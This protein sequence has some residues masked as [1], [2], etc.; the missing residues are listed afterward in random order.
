MNAQDLLSFLMLVTG[1]SPTPALVWRR[2][3]LFV[4][5][6]LVSFYVIVSFGRPPLPLLCCIVPSGVCIIGGP[7]SVCLHRYF[8]HAA[9]KTSRLGQFVLACVACCAWQRGPVWWASKHRRHHKLCDTPEDPHSAV[10]TTYAYAFFGWLFAAKEYA[11]DEEFVTKLYSFPEL[12]V[13]EECWAVP[14]ILL[15]AALWRACGPH[16]MICLLTLPMFVSIVV[17]LLINVEFHPAHETLFV[18]VLSTEDC[19]AVDLL[20]PI[21]ELVGESFHMDHHEYPRKAMKPGLD[22]PGRLILAPLFW[23]GLIWLPQTHSR[24]V[25]DEPEPDDLPPGRRGVEE[26]VAAADVLRKRSS[27]VRLATVGLDDVVG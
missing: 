8:S 22:L 11:I 2:A 25:D 1:E 10:Q 16:A 6:L 24:V 3:W 18:A 23:L 13:L 4:L 19:K 17:T 27:K 9:F 26:V 20:H 12:R 14:P 15:N 5:P 7:V 21:T